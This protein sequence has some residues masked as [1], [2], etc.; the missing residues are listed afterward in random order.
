MA[1]SS[2]ALLEEAIGLRDRGELVQSLATVLR[3]LADGSNSPQGKLLLAQLFYLSDC[4]ELAK[5]VVVQLQGEYP[6]KE[7][8]IRLLCALDPSYVPKDSEEEGVDP[9]I[10]RESRP[11]STASSSVA[12]AMEG[13]TSLER[14]GLKDTPPASDAVIAETDFEFDDL[15]LLDDE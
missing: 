9:A 13:E 15:D 6:D 4:P 5:D 11:S 2:Q 12:S 3:V 8:L 14:S 10:S 1:E 7:T